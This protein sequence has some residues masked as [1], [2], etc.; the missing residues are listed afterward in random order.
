MIRIL[1]LILANVVLLLIALIIGLVPMIL[2]GAAF[3]ATRMWQA[4]WNG[5]A[6]LCAALSRATSRALRNR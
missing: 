5:T 3:I 6:G 2:G 1:L 4:G